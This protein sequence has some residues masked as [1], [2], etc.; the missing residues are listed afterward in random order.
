MFPQAIHMSDQLSAT[1]D[2]L[3]TGDMCLDPPFELDFSFVSATTFAPS[4]T[5]NQL[6]TGDMDLDPPFER[7]LSFAPATASAPPE[8]DLGLPTPI[9]D[10]AHPSQLTLPTTFTLLDADFDFPTPELDTAHPSQLVLPTTF[11]QPDADFDLTPDPDTGHPPRLVDAPQ[12]A[13]P[14]RAYSQARARPLG[15]PP[16]GKGTSSTSVNP[17][18]DLL[19]GIIDEPIWMKQKRTLAYFRST[20]KL[21]DL[22]NV[23]KHWYALEELLGFQGVVSVPRRVIL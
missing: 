1:P 3:N 6:G 12:L 11:T 21:G 4:A 14:T 16:S 7:Y 22:S 20:F 23:I 9:P 2:Q 17:S 18:P 5:P 13:A 15:L 8:T 10:T 19:A